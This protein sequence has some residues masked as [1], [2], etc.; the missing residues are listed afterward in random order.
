MKLDQ[1]SKIYEGLSN[2]ERAALSFRFIMDANDLELTRVADT[3]EFKS[4]RCHDAEYRCWVQGFFTLASL[5]GLIHWQQHS[6]LMATV[7]LRYA[8]IVGDTE[9]DL[10]EINARVVFYRRRLIAL[11]GALLNVCEKHSLDHHAIMKYAEA[12]PS[13]ETHGELLPDMEYQDEMI[14]ALAV[15]IDM[16]DDLE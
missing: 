4:Y 12:E 8:T 1:I 5:W 13:A 14:R 15:A 2:K 11:D 9:S 16:T 10:N 3:V 6:S 7:A